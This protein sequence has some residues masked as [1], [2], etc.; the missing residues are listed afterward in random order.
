[1][2][3]GSFWLGL[4][5]FISFLFVRVVSKLSRRWLAYHPAYLKRGLEYPE[6][7]V[8]T[9][10]GIGKSSGSAWGGEIPQ[11]VFLVIAAYIIRRSR[12]PGE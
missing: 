8:R 2:D 3:D 1:M 7:R 12:P 9:V 5:L 4:V 6:S 10:G 11:K